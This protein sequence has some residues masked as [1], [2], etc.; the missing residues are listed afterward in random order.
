MDPVS[1]AL[2]QNLRRIFVATLVPGAQ[3]ARQ[4]W[5]ATKLGMEIRARRQQERAL[6]LSQKNQVAKTFRYNSSFNSMIEGA[7]LLQFQKLDHVCKWYLIK[8][9]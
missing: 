3:L 5:D 1:V 9:I 2:P 7:N 8:D 4:A 6:I